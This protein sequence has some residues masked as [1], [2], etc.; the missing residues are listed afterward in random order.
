MKFRAV[1]AA[2]EAVRRYPEDPWPGMR[3]ANGA[4]DH[5]PGPLPGRRPCHSRPLPARSRW[6]RGSGRPT[7]TC[8][9]CSWLWDVRTRPGVPRPPTWPSTRPLGTDPKSA[10]RRCCWTPSAAGRAEAERMLDTASVHTVWGAAI[11][12]Q[13]ASWPDTAETAIRLLRRL[14]EPGRGAGGGPPWVLDS[15][16]WPQYLAHALAFRGHLREAFAVNERCCA[17]PSPRRGATSSTPSWISACSGSFRTR[18]LAR[19]SAAPSRRPPTGEASLLPA[20]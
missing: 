19:P 7:S 18:W 11:N 17:S 8:R 4:W 2:E 13:L 12:Q 14:G 20:T 6:I 16:M 1:A 9:H 3:S 5:E 10:W 15:V